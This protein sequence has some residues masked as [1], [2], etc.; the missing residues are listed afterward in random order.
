MVRL[1]PGGDI[2]AL[3]VC[4]ADTR[5][6][7]A[8]YRFPLQIHIG[9]MAS[10][11]IA[12]ARMFTCPWPMQFGGAELGATHSPSKPTGCL[13]SILLGSMGSAVPWSLPLSLPSLPCLFKHVPVVSGIV[14]NWL[15]GRRRGRVQ[16]NH[17]HHARPDQRPLRHGWW[18]VCLV[19]WLF[20]CLFGRSIACLV[21]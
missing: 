9:V 14:C 18:F 13:T 19:A 5:A 20:G 6:C 12:H 11:A 17:R 1:H 21:V 10:D 15:P 16:S 3:T 2:S 4:T 8:S 7:V